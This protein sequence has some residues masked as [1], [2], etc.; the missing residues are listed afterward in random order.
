MLCTGKRP[1]AAPDTTALLRMQVH[2][3]PLPPRRAA[4][5]KRI[6]EA[7]ERVILRALEKRP[8]DRFQNMTEFLTALDD[9]QE[10]QETLT[11]TVLRDRKPRRWRWRLMG[12][13]AAACIALGATGA[14]WARAHFLRLRTQALGAYQRWTG[15]GAPLR[16][17]GREPALPEA[18]V[19]E[20]ALPKVAPAPP[21][22]LDAAVARP[23]ADAAV[24]GELPDPPNPEAQAVERAPPLPTPPPPPNPAPV[25]V[26]PVVTPVATPHR[27]GAAP[28]AAEVREWRQQIEALI[29]EGKHQP[30]EEPT[31]RPRRRRE[32]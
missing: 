12:I 26:A 18:P 30:G 13:A 31:A 16:P 19:R 32:E 9:T 4:P 2:D 1:F 25:V 6:G 7:L 11:P 22:R 14:L 15:P 28:V 3:P 27:R 21:L 5:G 10:G 20:A 23:A 24:A 29:N 17:S 8:A